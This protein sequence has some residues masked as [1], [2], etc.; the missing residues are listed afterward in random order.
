MDPSSTVPGTIHP[1]AG[2]TPPPIGILDAPALAQMDRYLLLPALLG[3][4]KVACAKL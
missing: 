3:L 4:A 2:A 1:N